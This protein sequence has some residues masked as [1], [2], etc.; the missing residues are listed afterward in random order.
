MDERGQLNAATG[1]QGGGWARRA[2]GVGLG[3]LLALG[4]AGRLEA[5]TVCGTIITNVVTATMHSGAP[6]F[7]VYEVSYN[8]TA[9]LV[10][11]CPPSLRMA[12]YTNYPVASAGTIVTFKICIHNETNNSVWGVTITDA[13]PRN[14]V[15]EGWDG[16]W[17]GTYANGADG[18]FY[19]PGTGV[20]A[21]RPVDLET[22]GTF[23]Y[24]ASDASEIAAMAPGPPPPGQVGP[25]YLRWTIP[26]VGPESSACVTYQARVL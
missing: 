16:N 5:T 7:V 20:L 6:E 14:M 21:D 22:G 17:T 9:T 19:T 3:V 13:L 24:M 4:A 23:D 8:A 12:K 26:H 25:Y 1:T 18:D 15:W 10:V 2:A 11:A